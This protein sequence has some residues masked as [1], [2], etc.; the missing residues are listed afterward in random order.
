MLK[1]TGGDESG[2]R[3]VSQQGRPCVCASVRC[4]TFSQTE[5]LQ[6]QVPKPAQFRSLE[7]QN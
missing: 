6:G 3:A 1:K 2:C 7:G 5:W 4:D